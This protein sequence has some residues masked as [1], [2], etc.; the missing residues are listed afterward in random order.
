[1]WR[2]KYAY[3]Q[4]SLAKLNSL[5]V[6]AEK[7]L[8]LD[9]EEIWQRVQLTWEFKGEEKVVPLL[10]EI[11]NND[12]YKEFIWLVNSAYF[13]MGKI[14][15]SNYQDAR[16]IKY[17]EHAIKK[18]PNIT[19][20]GCEII[21]SFLQKQGKVEEAKSYLQRAEK[22][23]AVASQAQEERSWVRMNDE[24]KNHDLPEKEIKKICH[25]LSLISEIKTVYL[26]QKIVKNFPGNPLYILGITRKVGF[27]GEADSEVKNSQLRTQLHKEIEFP[28]DGFILILTG[29]HA[30]FEKKLRKIPNSMIYQNKK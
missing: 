2:Q 22:Y 24:F 27:W 28:G 17:I 12:A 14:L 25:Y 4:E 20:D 19:I 29:Q 3:A 10:K 30:I 9:A 16:G 5:N 18:D 7:Q 6:R 11:L 8:L 15:L 13:C 1:V 23:Y 21:Y 26:V